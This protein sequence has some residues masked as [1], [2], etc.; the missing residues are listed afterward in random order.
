[1][2]LISEKFQHS[3]YYKILVSVFIVLWFY[4]ITKIITYLTNNSNDILFNIFLAGIALIF[5]MLDDSKLNELYNITLFKDNPVPV[6]QT[7][8]N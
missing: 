7:M 8:S 4:A 2:R 1:M 3:N 5:F 6:I